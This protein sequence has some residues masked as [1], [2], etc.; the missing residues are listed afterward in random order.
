MFNFIANGQGRVVQS[1]APFA[2]SVLLAITPY[3]PWGSSGYRYVLM[4]GLELRRYGMMSEKWVGL[5][6]KH[7]GHQNHDDKSG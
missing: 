2:L 5:I 4:L 3:L 1:L 7:Y 6:C